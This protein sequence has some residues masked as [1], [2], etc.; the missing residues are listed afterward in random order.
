M[1]YGRKARGLGY[2]LRRLTEGSSSAWNDYRHR[3]EQ[4]RLEAKPIVGSPERFFAEVHS[5][6]YIW[7]SR[8]NYFGT[9]ISLPAAV[10]TARRVFG[11]YFMKTA[12]E[13]MP[14]FEGFL[15]RVQALS[16]D[17]HPN[18]PRKMIRNALIAASLLPPSRVFSYFQNLL[19]GAELESIAEFR[20]AQQPLILASFVRRTRQLIGELPRG[21]DDRPNN[22]VGVI[23]TG[24]YA[25]GTAIPGSDFDIGVLTRDGSEKDATDFMA[26]LRE[27]GEEQRWPQWNDWNIY[28]NVFPP[29]HALI[30]RY[31]S[32]LS[33]RVISPYPEVTAALGGESVWRPFWRPSWFQAF[34]QPFL[35]PLQRVFMRGV[36]WS[37]DGAPDAPK[38]SALGASAHAGLGLIAL[39]F[40][41]YPAYP[42]IA[43]LPLPLAG[44]VAVAVG[45]YA[46]SWG[47]FFAGGYL[48]GRES[49]RYLKTRW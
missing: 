6:G 11:R 49:W 5:L 18:R 27:I 17:E 41:I 31:Y 12:P 4:A 1:S 42:F 2:K 30:D 14:A 9:R 47:L 23:L 35:E 40:L 25:Y 32:G 39:A 8:G 20:S 16:R 44:K 36:I 46:L 19:P 15:E 29:E 33:Y 7:W 37:Y 10:G 21:P 13:S 24:S 38:P 3:H 34:L 43:V 22:V 48:G 45:A 28:Q 26:R